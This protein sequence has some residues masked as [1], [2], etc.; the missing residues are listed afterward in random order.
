MYSKC[1]EHLLHASHCS[2]LWREG[3]TSGPK[4][5]EQSEWE[6][7]IDEARELLARMDDGACGPPEGMAGERESL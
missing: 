3:G 4:Q 7:V 2:R 5:L 1:I 6:K